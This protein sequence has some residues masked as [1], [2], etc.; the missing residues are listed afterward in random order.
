M[1]IV[2]LEQDLLDLL[3]DTLIEKGDE[4]K[5][6][7]IIDMTNDSDCCG[8]EEEEKEEEEE[9]KENI[10]ED[11]VKERQLKRGRIQDF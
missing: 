11:K 6:L 7:D 8:C 4:H 5:V 10:F 1:P 2:Y 9:K 3:I